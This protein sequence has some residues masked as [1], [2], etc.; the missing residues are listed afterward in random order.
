M[1]NIKYANFG[2]ED[3]GKRIHPYM[4]RGMLMTIDV[5]EACRAA[6]IHEKIL[7]FPDGY[8]SKVGERGIRLSGGELQRVRDL[9]TTATTT[10]QLVTITFHR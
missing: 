2:A 10:C 1:S 9:C 7:S 3:N 8:L 6:S 4:L 5:Y